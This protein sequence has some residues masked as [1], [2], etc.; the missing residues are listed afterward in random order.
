MYLHD[1]RE[2]RQNPLTRTYIV[3]SYQ[4][5]KI[6]APFPHVHVAAE[7]PLHTPGRV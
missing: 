6:L 1:K 7:V 5:L 2:T 3:R 4:L